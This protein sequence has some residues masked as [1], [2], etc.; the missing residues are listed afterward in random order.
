MFE[1]PNCAAKYKVVRVEAPSE[2]TTDREIVC[3]SCGGPLYD[4][5]DKFLLKYFL[6]ER[7]RRRA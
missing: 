1:C 5:E 4:R 7:S 3:L 6:V 2:P